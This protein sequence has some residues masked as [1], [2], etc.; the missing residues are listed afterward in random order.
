MHF[1]HKIVASDSDG[2]EAFTNIIDQLCVK[3]S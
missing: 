2:D 3:E 1:S